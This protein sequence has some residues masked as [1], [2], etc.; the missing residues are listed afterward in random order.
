M[1]PSGEVVEDEEQ[2]GEDGEG[3]QGRVAVPPAVIRR[4][5]EFAGDEGLARPR[6]ASPSSVLRSVSRD[7]RHPVEPPAPPEVI[8]LA[9]LYSGEEGDSRPLTAAPS[10]RP[11]AA[12]GALNLRAIPV[13][14]M[15]VSSFPWEKI[16]FENARMARFIVGPMARRLQCF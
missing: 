13:N 12:V 3:G 1:L 10:R 4:A 2:E 8:Q 6:T 7:G 14:V 5:A 15:T 16:A 11:D 9:A